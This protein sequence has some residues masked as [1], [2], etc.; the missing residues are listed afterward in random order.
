M[1]SK[2]SNITELFHRFHQCEMQLRQGKIA[3]CLIAFKEGIEQSPAIPKTENEKNELR[4]G[5]EL[6]LKNLSA[7]KKFHDI[8][9]P[10]SFGDSDLETNLEFIKSMITAQEEEIVERIKKEDEAAEAQRLE[11]D[12]DKQMQQEAMRKKIEQA[13]GLIDQG[14]LPPAMEIVGEREE[15]RE[16]VALHYNDVGMQCREDKSFAESMKNY[17][18]ALMVSPEDENLHYNMGRAHFEAGDSG[19]AEEFLANAM[20]L[21]PEFK[22]GKIFYDYLLK[23]NQPRSAPAESENKSGGFLQKIFH[24]KS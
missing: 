17:G 22:E 21:N 12:R 9:G 8:F 1:A 23:V 19:K 13:I 5:V 7:H 15:I 20:K 4:Q 16:T 18:K 14:N 2:I 6:F 3:A 24:R 10:V 11:I